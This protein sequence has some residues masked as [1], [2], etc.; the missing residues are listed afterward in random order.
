MIN[1]NLI[2][3]VYNVEKANH[4]S[5]LLIQSTINIKIKTTII[6]INQLPTKL[7]IIATKPITNIIGKNTK[8]NG[9]NTIVKGIDG[10]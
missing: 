1:V 6:T 2:S 9:I 10:L 5:L 7:N 4:Y 3:I 8:P